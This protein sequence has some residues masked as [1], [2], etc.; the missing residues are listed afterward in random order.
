LRLPF[1]ADRPLRSRDV[2]L[3][4]VRQRSVL[5]EGTDANAGRFV[6]DYT[7]LYDTAEYGFDVG[8]ANQ[9]DISLLDVSTY[10]TVA[11]GNY[12]RYLTA[13]GDAFAFAGASARSSSSYASLGCR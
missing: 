2:V 5:V 1:S 11:D 3:L 9:L 4:P 12:K 10:S 13:D 6:V 7:R 8:I